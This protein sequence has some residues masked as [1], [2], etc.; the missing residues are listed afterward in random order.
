M[1]PKRKSK[2]KSLPLYTTLQVKYDADN[3][4]GGQ[5]SQSWMKN[6]RPNQ[7]KRT[8]AV[9][10]LPILSS[11]YKVDLTVKSQ[12][13]L[14]HICGTA[15][16]NVLNTD[17][18]STQLVMNDICSSSYST[19]TS[20]MDCNTGS[21]QLAGNNICKSS[22][23]F[24]SLQNHHETTLS[25][26]N[27]V[28]GQCLQSTSRYTARVLF[29]YANPKIHRNNVSLLVNNDGETV[30]NE[31]EIDNTFVGLSALST[32]YKHFNLNTSRLI[33]VGDMLRLFSLDDA[34]RELKS[35]K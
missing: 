7:I 5:Q 13:I 30:T 20:V 28:D 18:N 17:V 9:I 15:N 31:V 8:T 25:I 24:N 19:N 1:V 3:D 33:T 34:Y 29:K 10:A 21:T 6:K 32:D 26:R 2:N 16:T 14:P 27:E 23:V 12:A 35:I 11:E 4:R 22:Y